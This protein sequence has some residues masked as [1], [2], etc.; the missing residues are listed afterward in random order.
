MFLTLNMFRGCSNY[1]EQ[2][3]S[4]LIIL[5]GM[6]VYIHFYISF[7]AVSSVKE[8]LYTAITFACGAAL[9]IIDMGFDMNI[10]NV[11]ENIQKH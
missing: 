10:Y 9:F 8:L 11:F 5:L 4:N 1:P 7:F 6:M 3:S 2:C